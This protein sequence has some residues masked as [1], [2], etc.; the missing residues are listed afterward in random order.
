MVTARYASRRVVVSRT[1]KEIEK[2]VES[3]LRETEKSLR[4]QV[5]YLNTLLQNLNE[6]FYTYDSNG[7]ITFGNQK[8]CDCMGCKM[9]EL[10]GKHVLDFV[11]PEDKEKIIREIMVRIKKG[12][13]LIRAAIIRR[14]VP[15]V[16]QTQC[17]PYGEGKIVAG[18]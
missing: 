2:P 10:V 17:S 9:E 12:S 6:I 1:G 11:P 4:K 7:I 18:W 3:A 13:W 5:D 14:M 16:V 8:A 15:A